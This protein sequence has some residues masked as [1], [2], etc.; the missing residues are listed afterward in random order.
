MDKRSIF[1]VFAIVLL[2]FAGIFIANAQTFEEENYNCFT[3]IVGKDATVDGSVMF[4]HNEDDWGERLVNWYHVPAQKNTKPDSVQ[5]KNGGYLKAAKET[6][7]YLWLEMPEMEFSD[8]YMN[9][10]GVTI[11]SDACQSREDKADLTDGGIGY[12]LR[13]AM[14]ERGRTAK[15]AVKIGGMLVEQFGYSSSGRTYCVADPNEAWMMSVVK[16]KHWV[17]QRIPDDHMAIIPNY[18]TISTVN[19]NDTVNFLGSEN[20]ID[21]AI[22]RGWFSAEAPGDFSFREAYSDQGNLKSLGNTARHWVT[23]NA[24][25]RDHYELEDEFPFSFIPKKPVKLENIFTA[26]RNHYEGTDLDKT[27]N[28][29]LGHPHDQ[30]AMSVCS[31]TNQYGFVAQLRNAMPVE[32]GVVLWLA[33]RRPC[34]QAFVPWYQGMNSIPEAY[35]NN[36]YKTAL[37]NHWKPIENVSKFAPDHQFPEYTAFGQKVDKN[38][39]KLISDV[40][41]QIKTLET[42]LLKSQVMIEAEALKVYKSSPEQ[43]NEL[44][45]KYTLLQIQKAEDLMK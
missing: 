19:L 16:G 40:Q 20:L 31:S 1:T 2:S 23:I 37:K 28:Y 26:L 33:P 22:E 25:S 39:S 9:E 42:E 32:I 18:Y 21:Y 12:W 6:W 11:A 8:S 34:T 24:F 29:E 14:A 13:R 3:I 7:K 38:Y 10:W 15:E 41:M 36:D 30:S 27:N 4:A 17:A 35:S 5:L 45:T 43:A 44:L